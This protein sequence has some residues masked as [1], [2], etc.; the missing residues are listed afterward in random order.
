MPK[1]ATYRP[2]VSWK[3]KYHKKVATESGIYT[4]FV[5]SLDVERNFAEYTWIQLPV[6]DL[7]ELGMGLLYSIL[8]IEYQPLTVDFEYVRPT[9]D[10]TLQ[11]VWAKFEPVRFDKLYIWLTDFREYVIE[12]FKVEYQPEVILGILQKAVY[13]TTPY[14]RGLYDPIVAREFLRSTFQK[15]RLMRLPDIH[16]ASMLDHIVEFI[17]MIGVTDEHVFNR[18]M[19]TFSVQVNS[20]VLGLSLLGRS[21]LAEREGE[22]AKAPVKDAKGVIHELR[23]RTLDH[24]QLGF[25]LGLTPLSYGLLLPKESIY[26]LPEGKRNPS[27]I[28]LVQEKTR[29]IIH[30]LTLLPWSYA[31]Y[32][33]PDEMLDVHKSDKANQF[34][35]IQEMR[36]FVE[37]WVYERIPPEESNSVRIRQYQNAVLQLVF[38]RAKRHRWGFQ[39]WE[40]MDEA[41][42]KSWWKGYWKGQGLNEM[43]LESLYEGIEPWLRRL[44]EVRLDVGK[45][46]KQRR[47]RLALS[48]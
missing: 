39:G 6:F 43:T 27:I 45:K 30:R 9:P 13:G 5:R 35:L 36:K 16:W 14:G 26:S 11:G 44:R 23:F 3:R 41:Q 47:L 7:T 24:L 15:L 31:N 2:I 8:P 20:F 48:V 38:F 33:K 1:R 46:V 42:F 28:R 10:E 22:Y 4:T 12:N 40:A 19:M 37:R 34:A 32:N 17:E 18:L 25:I 21:R 29:G